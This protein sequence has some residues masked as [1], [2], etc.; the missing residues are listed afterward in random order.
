MTRDPK[1]RERGWQIFEALEKRA[2]LPLGFA[3][4]VDVSVPKE[5]IESGDKFLKN[6]MP[7]WFLAETFVVYVL[8]L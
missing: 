6:E 8:S 2:R 3:S 7:S 1:W 5:A 4:V